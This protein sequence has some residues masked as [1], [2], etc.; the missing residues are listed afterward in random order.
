MEVVENTQNKLFKGQDF[1]LS[2]RGEGGEQ[3]STKSRLQAK[4]QAY[5][6]LLH[7]H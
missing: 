1:W 4:G 3:K 6:S 2:R 7:M 5:N